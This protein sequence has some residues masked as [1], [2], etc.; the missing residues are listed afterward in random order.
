MNQ[1]FTWIGTLVYLILVAVLVTL[2]RRLL[3]RGPAARVL[4]WVVVAVIGLLVWAFISNLITGCR[5]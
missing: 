5:L 4:G 2:A 1:S 3:R